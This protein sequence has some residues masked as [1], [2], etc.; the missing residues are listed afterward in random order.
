MTNSAFNTVV[1]RTQSHTGHNNIRLVVHP[2]HTPNAELYM[3]M[4]QGQHFDG[5]SYHTP[6]PQYMRDLSDQLWQN[7]PGLNTLF[8]GNGHITLQHAG[9]F[10]DADI[11]EAA[12]QIMEPI[13]TANLALQSFS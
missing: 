12:T 9:V 13:L 3:M 5:D 7:I 6:M 1:I 2:F 8:F 10:D 4:Y 11:I